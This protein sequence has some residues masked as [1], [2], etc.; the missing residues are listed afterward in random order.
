MPERL[1][2]RKGVWYYVRRVPPEFAAFDPRGIVRLSTGV[3]I[4]DDRAGIKAAR[5]AA[6]KE[7]DLEASWKAATGHTARWRSGAGAPR[8]GAGPGVRL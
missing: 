8:A 3:R 6:S 5:I 4:R 2:K 1:T 7:I